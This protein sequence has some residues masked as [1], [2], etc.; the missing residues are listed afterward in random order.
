[1]CRLQ[2]VAEC[3]HCSWCLSVT[4]APFTEADQLGQHDWRPTAGWCMAFH[5]HVR[6]GR[7]SHTTAGLLDLCT[8]LIKPLVLFDGKLETYFTQ[9]WMHYTKLYIFNVD[10]S[11]TI[12]KVKMLVYSW[13]KCLNYILKNI[14]IYFKMFFYW[15]PKL[16]FQHQYSRLQCPMILH[17]S[18]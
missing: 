7:P 12:T 1:M 14:R 16:N 17:K 3:S 9:T 4:L 11:K 15:D 2:L 13:H 10:S 8:D 6:T 18:F 5:D